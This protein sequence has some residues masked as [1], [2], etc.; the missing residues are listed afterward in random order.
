MG[1]RPVGDH[2][3]GDGAI[4]D[5]RRAPD[6][7]HGRTALQPPTDPP[8]S[9]RGKLRN[10]GEGAQQTYTVR[11]AKKAAGRNQIRRSDV[12]RYRIAQLFHELCR[13]L[14]EFTAIQLLSC[15]HDVS[16]ADIR[17]FAAEFPSEPFWRL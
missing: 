1:N 7:L 6:S 2:L 15:R 16:P 17:A 3:F 5:G 10:Q 9:S 14:E 4:T 12:D 8:P 11:G 13:D